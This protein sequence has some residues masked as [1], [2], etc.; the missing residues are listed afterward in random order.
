[1]KSYVIQQGIG[2]PE[3][4]QT[5]VRLTGKPAME[6]GSVQHQWTD[7]HTVLL[8]LQDI[9]LVPEGRPILRIENLW[10]VSTKVRCIC[11]VK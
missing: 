6:E 10:E 8:Q 2:I 5:T 7:V 9:W 11:L 1:M 3:A 4:S